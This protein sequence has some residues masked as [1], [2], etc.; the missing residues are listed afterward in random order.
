MRL[1]SLLYIYLLGQVYW[2]LV[3]AT[4]E[5]S[6]TQLSDACSCRLQ[7]S[8]K[9]ISLKEIDGIDEARQVIL[10]CDL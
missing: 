3:V 8:G 6:C 1:I 5:D 7:K 2:A 4:E 9:I 10:Y